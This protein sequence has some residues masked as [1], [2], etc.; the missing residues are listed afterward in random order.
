MLGVIQGKCKIEKVEVHV[1]RNIPVVLL[2]VGDTRIPIFV[3]PTV[4][5][6]IQD[7]L[8]GKKLPRP[9]SHDLMQTILKTHRDTC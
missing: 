7:A 8:K 6:S 2:A 4:A 9:F 3:D 1:L 5:N